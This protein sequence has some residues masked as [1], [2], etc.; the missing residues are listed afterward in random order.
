MKG[1]SDCRRD[2][3]KLV[4]LYRTSGVDKVDFVTRC[5]QT[6]KKHNFAE[7]IV[8]LA[9]GVLT[10]WGSLDTLKKDNS[11]M[12]QLQQKTINDR[13]PPF[14]PNIDPWFL[15]TAQCGQ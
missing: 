10:V 3:S 14:L 8:L 13:G 7:K 6:K 4:L 1:V 12:G 11:G 2:R 15:C 9:S 5:A